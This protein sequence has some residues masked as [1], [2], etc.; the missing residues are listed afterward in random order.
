M[1]ICQTSHNSHTRGPE[2]SQAA[3]MITRLG[4]TPHR[5]INPRRL[6][7]DGHGRHAPLSC[8]RCGCT[9]AGTPQSPLGRNPPDP[10]KRVRC[11]LTGWGYLLVN[12]PNQ[13]E[14]KRIEI[15][16][17]G[18]NTAS[19]AAEPHLQT[20]TPGSRNVTRYHLDLHFAVRADRGK[21]PA[22][23]LHSLPAAAPPLAFS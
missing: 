19:T 18:T 4:K 7:R 10:K 15:P 22:W 5:G 23:E 2:L 12:R 3:A 20:G 13:T 11:Y 1:P 6:Q 21:P 9:C 17:I 8:H 16:K 14:L